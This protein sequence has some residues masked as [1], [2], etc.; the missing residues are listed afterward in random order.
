MVTPTGH[1]CI[2]IYTYTHCIHAWH[3]RF[4]TQSPACVILFHLFTLLFAQWGLQTFQHGG[5]LSELSSRFTSSCLAQPL[6]AR[7]P[8]PCASRW[9]P[10]ATSESPAG[11]NM[12][13]PRIALGEANQRQ[14]EKVSQMPCIASCVRLRGSNQ[15]SCCLSASMPDIS[16]SVAAVHKDILQI[17]AKR[18]HEKGRERE[19]EGGSEGIGI[20][21]RACSVMK[22][23]LRVCIRVSAVL[24][25]K[26]LL[27]KRTDVELNSFKQLFI[28]M[29]CIPH[30]SSAL[31]VFLPILGTSPDVQYVKS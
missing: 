8:T 2:H 26:A 11:L 24:V 27:L 31:S 12:K 4:T 14:R 10:S 17:D 30:Q 7:H 6:P 13:L 25:S 18:W 21:V 9:A 23:P 15:E 1:L 20:K 22:L 29:F 16:S 19:S 28:F 5:G 3:N